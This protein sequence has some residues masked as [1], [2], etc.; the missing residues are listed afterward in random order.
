MVLSCNVITKKKYY[1]MQIL[2]RLNEQ[3]KLFFCLFD[4]FIYSHP[5]LKVKKF[6]ENNEFTYEI[7]SIYGNIHKIHSFVDDSIIV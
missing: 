3:Q 7:R 5:I 4:L 1:L 6:F 2:S